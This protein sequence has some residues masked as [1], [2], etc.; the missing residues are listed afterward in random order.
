MKLKIKKDIEKLLIYRKSSLIDALKK[1]NESALKVLLVVDKDYHF[2]GTL[3]DGDIRRY[4]LKTGSL[5]GDISDIYNTN[6]FYIDSQSLTDRNLID[7]LRKII[8]EKKYSIV[9][10]LESKRVVGYIEWSDFLDNN[11]IDFFEKIEDDISCVIMAGGKGTRLK[12]FTEVLPKPLIPVKD[13]TLIELII[14]QFRKFG[15]NK[16][17]ITL[18]YKGK[19]IETYLDTL[20]KDFEVEFIYE[21]DYLG[22]AGSLSLLKNHIKGDFFVSNCDILVNT[23]LK[24][25]YDFHKQKNAYLTS[26]TS[27]LHYKIPY[28]VVN[29]NEGGIIEG[30]LEKPE[31]TFQINTGIYLVNERTLNYIPDNTYFDMPQL[32]NKLLEENKETYAYPVKEK[33]YIDFGQWEE[34]KKA[35]EVLEV[36]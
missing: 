26:I 21:E 12:P 15:I 5:E 20:E 31:Y 6:P 25:V 1:L 3:S 35:L 7:N 30:I 36:R 17:F 2:L 34:Y 23:D 4:I 16:F 32:I 10:V 29:I 19:L 14:E 33:D 18:N 28:G 9:P 24:K 11:E 22:T 27:I 13:K 8:K